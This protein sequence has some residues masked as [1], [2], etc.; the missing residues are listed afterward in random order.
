MRKVIT[1]M[2]EHSNFIFS[3]KFESGLRRLISIE[4]ILA[5]FKNLRYIIKIQILNWKEAMT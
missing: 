5:L 1:F 2:H 4:F 3:F